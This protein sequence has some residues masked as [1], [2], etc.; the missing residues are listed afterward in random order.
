MAMFQTQRERFLGGL[1]ALVVLVGG[2]YF[3]AFKPGMD[4]YKTLDDQIRGREKTL[5][6]KRVRYQKSK[7]IRARFEKIKNTLS[8]QGTEQE[9]RQQIADELISLLE[10]VDI[11]AQ[12]LSEPQADQVDDEFR[13]YSFRLRGIRTTRETLARLLY[14]IQNSDAVL[15]VSSLNVKRSSRRGDK[16]EELSVDLQI[17]RLVEHKVDRKR[18]R[19]RRS[20][21]S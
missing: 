7:Q 6:E 11:V 13:I 5:R 19:S 18:K 4:F 14:E 9:K 3:F 2:G 12:N 15:E 8:L 17:S 21:R 20:R 10:G 16:G 1:T